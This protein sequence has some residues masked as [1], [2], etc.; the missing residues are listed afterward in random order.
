M[1]T[2]TTGSEEISS[3]ELLDKTGIS[4]ATLNNYIKMGIVPKPNVK[5]PD[6]GTAKTK[7]IGYFPGWVVTRILAIQRMK[8]EGMSMTLIVNEMTEDREG[9]RQNEFRPAARER[10]ERQTAAERQ[11]PSGG[12]GE[13]QRASGPAPGEDP[14]ERSRREP[15]PEPDAQ[16]NFD[17]DS[18]Q[19]PAYLL[20]NSYEIEWINESAEQNLLHRD[21]RSMKSASDRNIFRLFFGWEFQNNMNNWE[22]MVRIHLALVKE[23]HGVEYLPEIYEGISQ[24]EAR[25]LERCF[26][27]IT[28][29]PAGVMRKMSVK[30]QRPDGRE[31]LYSVYVTFFREG[32]FFIYENQEAMLEG[33]SDLLQDR[34]AV[35][36]DLMS[37]KMPAMIPFC[38]L[39]ADL[40]DSCRICTELPPE[41][42]FEIVNDMW[43]T[44]E[45]TYKKY[46]GIYGKHVGDGM[47]YYFLKKGDSSYLVNAL[48]CALEIRD[49][50]MEF[51]QKWKT[52]KKWFNTLY[53]NI[54]LNEGEEFFGTVRGS[55]GIEFTALGDTIN[56]AARLSSLARNGSIYTTKNLI[57]RMAE[58]D[59]KRFRI[60]IR[61]TGHEGPVFIE[62]VYSRVIDL[63]DKDH[64]EQGKLM[65]I[66]ALPVTEVT[67][68]IDHDG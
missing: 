29:S 58:G 41:E 68:R 9:N 65:D 22:E 34:G 32:I 24:G 37:L 33:I 25:F 66:G 57:N 42:Y 67:A 54:G 56:C 7:R 21:V 10:R 18:I 11:G 4:R 35:I 49:R 31:E 2:Q 23:R 19:A 60:G 1:T 13:E 62:N 61:K 48:S 50:M 16:L 55:T 43:K 8:Q 14:P 46:Y 44:L 28:A 38:V 17:L 64:R 15:L 53:L 45:E 52:R 27:E 6:S 20:N 5:I 47:V 30:V 39:V 36:R 59:R 12:L 26:E 51:S 63:L 3:K 40:Q